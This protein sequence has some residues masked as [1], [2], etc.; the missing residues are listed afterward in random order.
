MESRKKRK[1]WILLSVCVLLIVL[2]GILGRRF[3][4]IRSPLTEIFS[5]VTRWMNDVGE[6]LDKRSHGLDSREELL[7][8]ISG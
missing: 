5:P 2:S 1:I 3:N 4:F 7:D 8:Q 6:W